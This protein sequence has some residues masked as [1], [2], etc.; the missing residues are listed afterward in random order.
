MSTPADVSQSS[1][2]TLSGLPLSFRLDWP[3]RPASSGADFHV[4]HTEITPVNP[5]GCGAG[6]GNLSVTLR[7]VLP[8]LEPRMSAPRSFVKM[9]TTNR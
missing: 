3:F 6:R 9:S 7:E 2:V 4:L 8:S 1:A 5:A